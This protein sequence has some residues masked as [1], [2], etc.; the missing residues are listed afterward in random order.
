V[1]AIQELDAAIAATQLEVN[2]FT[3]VGNTVAVAD[4]NRKIAA[5]QLEKTRRGG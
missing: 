5:Y 1:T 3:A 4:L 2:R